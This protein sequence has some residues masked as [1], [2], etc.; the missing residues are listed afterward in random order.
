MRSNLFRTKNLREILRTAEQADT[1][2]KRVLGWPELTLLGIGAIIGAGIFAL[3]GTAAAGSGGRLGSGPAIMLAFVL[4]AVACALSA[5]AY[6]EFASIVPISGSAY[7]YSYFTLGELIAWIIG[8][9]LIL[10]YAVGNIAVAV[11]WSGYMV[12]LLKGFG[13]EIPW[14]LATTY[15]DPRI[16]GDMLAAAP[17]LFGL[18]LVINVPAVF[19]VFLITAVLV[20]GIKESSNF[21]TLMVIIKLIVVIFF[22][23]VGSFYVK[24]S[25]WVPFAPNGWGPIMTT[26]AIIFFAYIGFD[27]ISTA[28][29]ETKNPQRDL[30]IAMIASL[31]VCTVLY[32]AVAAVLTGIIPWNQLNVSEPLSL[33]FSY[34]K[35]DWAA[36]IVAFGA[37]VATTAV[38]LVFQMGQPRIFFSMSRD[39]LLPPVFARVHPRF[40]TP[41]VTTILSGVFVAFFAAFMDIGEAANLSSIGTLFAFVLVS[42][43]VIVLRR[44]DPHLRRP[45][46]TPF[47]PVVPILGMLTCGGLMISLP[48]TTWV[49]FVVWLAIGLTIYFLY[50]RRHSRLVRTEGSNPET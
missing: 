40:R 6:A 49:R 33:A 42:G 31:V 28:A 36:G 5:L 8:W 3:V 12:Q 26:A 4:T 44:R 47:V 24:P 35:M 25:N 43:G 13:I 29:E 22:I 23:V 34:L 16:T 14:W 1:Q 27:A 20:I 39:G 18:P 7:T 11:S 37:V 17:H 2:L 19:I 15:T 30:P 50:S 46:R 21:N 9:D 48:W 38:L 32:V 10:E 45:F 41:H